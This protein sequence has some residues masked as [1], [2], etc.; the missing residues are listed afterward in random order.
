[1]SDEKPPFD[2]N[3]PFEAEKPAFNP[4]QPFETPKDFSWSK[5]VTDIPSEI[6]NEAGKAWSDI[7]A[8]SNRGQQ[9]PIEGLLTTGKAALAVP[10]LAMSP[11]T[12]AARSLVGH[13]MANLEHKA[14]EYINPEVAAKD[15]PEKMYETAKGDVDTAMSA[16]RPAG[17][18]VKIAGAYEWKTPKPSQSPAVGVTKQPETEAFFDAADANYSNMRGL[19]VE[20]H[21]QAMNRVADNILTELHT[22]GYRP[23]NAPGVFDAVEELR[24]PAG[25]NHEISD[26][27][28]V[29][30]VLNRARMDPA[31]RDAA[32]RAINHIDDYLADL[33]KNPNDIVVNPH[34]AQKLSDEA[35]AARA[36]YAAAKRAEDVD[37]ALDKAER[38]AARA[39]SGGNINNAI[40]QALS[41][42]RNNKKKMAG[43][44]DAEKAELDAV[45]NGSRTGNAARQAGKFAPHGIVSTVMSAGAG[46]ALMPGIGEIAVPGLGFIAKKIGDRITQS[47]ADR[48]SN[49]IKSRS[50]LGK[51]TSINTAAQSAF[52]PQSSRPAITS[53]VANA[54]LPSPTQNLPLRQIQNLMG[55]AAD[56]EKKRPRKRDNEPDQGAGGK[57]HGGGIRRETGGAVKRALQSLQEYADGGAT[58]ISGVGLRP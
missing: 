8:L 38:A 33:H 58:E 15:D 20:I 29:R 53:T 22:E 26:I 28:S 19:G 39:G 35:V 6:G 18:P 42:L 51:Q 31:Q 24:A 47:G 30:K 32:R 4:D 27:D 45:I 1:M 23:R 2:P 14:G 49:V 3:K 50:P 43:W 46:H 48:L 44:T 12:G 11:V 52:A 21:P 16:M 5:A 9:G 17:N 36:N 41:S 34:F 55:A 10:R 25:A 13:T 57:S 40:R 56:D 37:E 54:G 7:S